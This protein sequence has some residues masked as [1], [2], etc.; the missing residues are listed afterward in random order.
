M[1]LPRDKNRINARTAAGILDCQETKL[2]ILAGLNLI[3][4][5]RVPG[6][7]ARYLRADVEALVRK[8]T[9]LANLD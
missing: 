1:R 2:P 5:R 4:V 7:A 3:T 8:S 6:C 9:H